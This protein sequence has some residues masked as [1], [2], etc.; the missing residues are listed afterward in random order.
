MKLVLRSLVVGLTAL[1]VTAPS[2]AQS[3]TDSP[4]INYPD[5]FV[6]VVAQNGMVASQEAV[7]TRVGVEILKQGGN[8]IDAAVA[9]GFALA[10][11]FPQAGNIGGGGFMMVHLAK[12]NKTI[13]IDYRE[14]APAKAHRDLYLDEQGNVDTQ[15]ARF[16][17]QSAGVPGTV[18]GLIHALE[19]YGTMSLKQVMAPAIKLA[20]EGFVVGYALEA[21]LAS[22][23]KRLGTDPA[24][25]KVFFKDGKSYRFGETLVQK[26]LAKTLKA[27]SEK[28]RAGFYKGDVADLI[29]ADMQANDGLI[30]HEDLENYRVVEREAI[31]GTYKDFEVVT[32]PPPSSGGVHLVQMLNMLENDDLAKKGHNSAATLHLMIESMRQAY[33]DR[34]EYL[35]DPDY[36]E[37]PITK[38]TDKAYAKKLRAMIPEK[39]ARKSDDV[40]PALPFLAESPDTTHF[41]VMDKQGNAV[42]NTYTLNFSYGSHI[43]VPGAGFILNNEMD[44]FSAK[45]GVANA[46]GLLGAE[47]NSIAAGKRP[48]SSMTPT[49]L[50]KD[51]K[52]LMAT[53]SP[54]GSTIITAVL[55]V[56]LNV[57][58]HDMNVAAATFAP[59]IHHQ[60]YP[61]F[62]MVERGINQDSK[63]L[64]KSWGHNLSDR[65]RTIGSTQ[66]IMLKDGY[67]Y[68]ASDSRR[69]GALTEGY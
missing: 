24:A 19:K 53:G 66:T 17:R 13:A 49:L 33:A 20:E 46:Y 62:I 7:A 48:L 1:C 4:I 31:R 16:S 58:E 23:T 60:W 50:F 44:D 11:T 45:V 15:R 56:V 32:M 40:K 69:L 57:M 36:F 42:S 14:M 30:T 27:I 59:R 29:V 5:R 6:P 2:L 52:I 37:V 10:V 47:A 26:D 67:F 39:Q 38:L 68:G 28:G 3:N 9:T 51:G 64:L 25:S 41:S 43:M 63:D 12:E 18:A 21:S 55:Q 8:A 65:S 35:G 54:G 34:S 22:R 61:D